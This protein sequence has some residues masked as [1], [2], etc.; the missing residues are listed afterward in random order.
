MI[1]KFW[2]WIA[3]IMIRIALH[4]V[5]VVYTL[6]LQHNTILY[7]YTVTEMHMFF[8]R[9]RLQSTGKSITCTQVS[10]SIDNDLD[11]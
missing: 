5:V 2:I 6:Q 7:Y 4:S 10:K 3:D 1:S 9:S 11:D 8:V